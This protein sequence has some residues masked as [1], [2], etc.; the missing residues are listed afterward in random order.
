MYKSLQASRAIAALF[1]VLF[2][3]GGAV[4]AEKYFNIHAFSLPFSF[5]NAGV[6]FFFVLSGFIILSSHK[7]DLFRPSALGSYIKKRIVRVYPTYWIVFLSVM[8]IALLSPQ[9]RTTVPSGIWLMVK[10]L[11]LLPVSDA[12]PGGAPL[13]TVSWTLRY[14]IFFYACFSLLLLSRWISIFA[15]IVLVGI[16]AFFWDAPH[17]PFPVDSFSF[18]Y[19]FLFVLGMIVALLV[20]NRRIVFGH[21]KNYAIVGGILFAATALDTVLNLKFVTYKTLV[22]GVS[23]SLMIFGLVRIEANGKTIGHQRWLQVLGGAS[24]ALYLIHYPMIS[25]LCKLA[26]ALRMPSLGVIGATIT[27]VVIL[28]VCVISAVAFHRFLE[29]P[30]SKHLKAYL[31]E[32]RSS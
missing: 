26:M 1:V 5:G 12:D 27:F 31:V 14:E 22:Y 32:K 23:S 30:L 15:G 29:I 18:S 9:L 8:G 7:Q 16:Y 13:L 2:H 19:V 3:L 21:P 24:Y 28:G 17:P 20:S 10:S 11:L 25:I 4:S 6:E